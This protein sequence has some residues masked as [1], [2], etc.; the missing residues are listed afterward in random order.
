MDA[1]D[2]CPFDGGVFQND[3]KTGRHVTAVAHDTNPT[4][5]RV[6]RIVLDREYEPVVT[7]DARR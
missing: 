3:P 5:F 1:Y 6:Y 4:G 7:V 2:A